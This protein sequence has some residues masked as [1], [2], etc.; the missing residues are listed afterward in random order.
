M[1]RIHILDCTLRDGGYI[2]S[3]DFGKSAIRDI[4]KG[5]AESSIDVIEC[6]FLRAGCTDE[7]KTLFPSIKS[8][9]WY[10]GEKHHNVLY[11][12][13]IQYG[14]IGIDEIEDCKGNSIDGIRLSF[15]EH[16]IEPSLIM[17]KRLQD[18]GYKVF[19]QPVG[20][21]AY[22]DEEL[23][24]LIKKINALKPYA[25]YMVDTL[26]K[27]YKQD[28]L[29]MF[30]L[31]DHNLSPDIVL[32]FH[33]HNNL[34]MSF[35]NAQELTQISTVR[36]LI[37][38]SSIL[39]MGRGAGNLNT[40]LLAQYL[41][42]NQ[43]FEY[44]V[45]KILNLMDL[46]IRPLTKIYRWGYDA[47]YYLAAV[48]GCHPNYAAFLLDKQTLQIRDI[49]VILNGMDESKRHLF[50]KSYIHA[51]Y[52]KYMDHSVDDLEVCDRLRE[53]IGTKT[54]LLL[55]PGKS[56]KASANRLTQVIED[57]HPFVISVNFV[58][59]AIPIDIVFVSN[60]R[61]FSG[62]ADLYK[63]TK[64]QIV[65][66]SNIVHEDGKLW[67]V[68]YSSYLN[69][70][71]CILD[72]AGLMCM[73]VLKKIG[74]KKI[75]LAGFDGFS[76]ALDDNFYEKSMRI[77]IEYERAVEMNRAISQKL[78][79]LKKQMEITFFDASEYARLGE[80]EECNV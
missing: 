59:E 9:E 14:A 56:L 78:S 31:V 66:T 26:G 29:R 64:A 61:R 42:V 35:A 44:D 33:S 43:D 8:M 36:K 37:I 73:Q 3:F 5:L 22:S 41:N 67:V 68:N 80:N 76:A 18:K 16:E 28:L 2:N 54:V 62:I 7:N 30:Y 23:L 40:E 15:H 79:Q 69:E 12:A 77:D 10:I 19:M 65:V 6:G 13:M 21:T 47:A 38:D 52:L 51:E 74:V 11:V 20:T 49:G 75:V 39:G 32:G 17:A 57:H 4:I 45:F 50:D 25:F 58:P 60:I 71:M 46:Y 1:S 34:Q 70:N 24:A 53:S 27:M 72:N 55:A 63:Y 48:T